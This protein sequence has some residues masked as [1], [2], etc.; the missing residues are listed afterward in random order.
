MMKKTKTGV[1]ILLFLLM[2]TMLHASAGVTFY[3]SKS[4]NLYQL[5]SAHGVRVDL[6]GRLEQAIEAAP[7]NTGLIITAENSVLQPRGCLNSPGLG[8]SAFARHYLRNHFCFLLLRVLRCFSSPGLPPYFKDDTA[9]PY[10]VVPFGYLRINGY[11]HLPKAFRSLSRPSSPLR[12][13]AS[14]MRPYL[15]LF[16]IFD[17]WFPRYFHSGSPHTGF[18]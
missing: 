7:K 12:A 15:F 14:A 1:F 2:G 8:F 10:R 16:C 9:S 5:L 4:N 6:Y 11:L 18:F 13:K 3:G 17:M